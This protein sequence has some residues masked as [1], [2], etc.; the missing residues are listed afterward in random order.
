MEVLPNLT[1]LKSVD[2][3]LQ[4]YNS[5]R[6]NPKYYGILNVIKN[7]VLGNADIALES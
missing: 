6:G 2:R 7:K 1:P 5:M 3:V 4:I